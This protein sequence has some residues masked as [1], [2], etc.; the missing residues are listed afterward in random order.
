MR[1]SLIGTVIGAI[2][3]A[4]GPIGAFIAYDQARRFSKDRSRFGK[5]PRRA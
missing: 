3:G 2:P 4:S 5:A 1:S